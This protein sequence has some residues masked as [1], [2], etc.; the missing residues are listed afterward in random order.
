[1]R[2]LVGIKY[3]GGCNPTYDRLA[4]VEAM[5]VRLAGVVDWAASNHDDCDVWVAVMGCDTA[6]ADLTTCGGAE[7]H[8]ITS[9]QDLETF[10]VRMGIK[11]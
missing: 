3:C 2:P 6:C 1:M 9:P 5:K 4:L 10:L 8:L 7:V 11:G